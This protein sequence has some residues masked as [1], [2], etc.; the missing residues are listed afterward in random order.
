LQDNSL[1]YANR[2]FT[3]HNSA[4]YPHSYIGEGPNVTFSFPHLSHLIFI[5]ENCPFCLNFNQVVG[6]Q[7]SF[8]LAPGK[9]M[10]LKTSSPA[11]MTISARVNISGTVNFDDGVTLKLLQGGDISLS[12]MY[13]PETSALELH[14]S[15]TKLS[16]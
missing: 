6:C 7:S 5:D 8:V 16:S 10:F 9:S 2:S 1:L 13:V 4:L 14:G 11:T 3:L 12:T 15:G